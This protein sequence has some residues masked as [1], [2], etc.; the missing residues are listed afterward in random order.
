MA[1]WFLYLFPQNSCLVA[2]IWKISWVRRSKMASLAH[3]VVDVGCWLGC[4]VFLYVSTYAPEANPTGPA[5]WHGS[6]RTA[7]PRREWLKLWAS[8]GLGSTHH[9]CHILLA[10]THHKSNSDSRGGETDSTSFSLWYLKR[11]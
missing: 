6:I 5:T 11:T 1:G 2:I 8:W 9:C 7:C 3:R 10:K 4:L